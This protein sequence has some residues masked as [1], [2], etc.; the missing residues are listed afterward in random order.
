ML[1]L[2]QIAF[3]VVA[4]V[5]SCFYGVKAVDALIGKQEGKSWAWW[6][7]Q[8]WLNFFGSA[9]G[10]AAGYYLA[11]YRLFPVHCYSF[12]IEDTVPILIALLGMTGLLPYT[13]SKLT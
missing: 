11:F 13:L 9:V 1:T 2:P 7:H 6:V 8:I 3:L 12:K 10:W 5:F 4:T